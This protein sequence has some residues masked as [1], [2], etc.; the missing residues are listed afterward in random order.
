MNTGD[1]KK[2]AGLELT[3][4]EAYA[5]LAMCLTSPQGIDGTSEAAIRKLAAF[6]IELSNRTH[7]VDLLGRAECELEKAGA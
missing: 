1:E 2:P 6:C 7:A 5:I 3:E 4:E